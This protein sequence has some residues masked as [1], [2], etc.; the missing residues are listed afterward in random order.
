MIDAALSGFTPLQWAAMLA[1]AAASGVVHGFVGIG[2]PLLA[3]PLFGLMFGWQ[4]AV[5]LL[6]LPTLLVTLGPLL[7]F[8]GQ[9]D[10]RAAAR[11]YWPLAALMPV[12]LW[13]G[14]AAL[15][16]VP[17]DALML[18]MA[19]VL[20]AYL[21]LDRLGR[22]DLPWAR[23][24][25]TLLAAPFGLAAGF[26]EGALNVAGPVLLIFFLLLD[27][28][29][30]SII[31]TMNWLFLAGKSVQAVLMARHGAFDGGVLAATLP[32]A[33]L[34][35]AGYAGGFALRRRA[36]PA[37]YRGWLKAM[38]AVM[39]LGLVARVAAGGAA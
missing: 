33:V 19:A 12:G 14:V 6:V 37:R 32:I 15:H 1:I 27:L 9:G 34:G 28:P 17:A 39:A 2:F 4:A 31:A 5:G 26:S 7:A 30:A 18:L 8:R 16:A 38:L 21:V 20:A 11:V 23:A 35:L 13:G 22:T 10:L 36:D 25:P 29:V 3:T 24:H